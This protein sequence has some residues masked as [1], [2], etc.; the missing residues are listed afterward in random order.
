MLTKKKKEVEKEVKAYV[1]D[2]TLKGAA[3]VAA[4]ILKGIGYVTA[5]I[6]STVFL[7]KTLGN[8]KATEK[9]G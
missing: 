2:K 4:P 8:K 9:E 6:A 7:F 3:K 5:G 1:G